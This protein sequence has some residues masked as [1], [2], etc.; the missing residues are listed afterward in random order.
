LGTCPDQACV[1][2]DGSTIAPRR[3]TSLVDKIA[4]KFPSA[5]CLQGLL[6]FYALYLL[7]AMFGRWMAVVPGAPVTVWPPNGVILAALLMHRKETWPWW[8][9]VGVIGEVTGNIFWYNSTFFAAV[10]YIFANS[11]AV[12]VAGLLMYPRFKEPIRRLTKLSEVLSLVAYGVLLTPIISATIGSALVA[13]EGKSAF[14]ATWP[15][16]WL[17]DATGVLIA[18]PFTIAAVNAWRDRSWPNLKQFCEGLA[19]AV[20]L[21]GITIWDLATGSIYTF[22]LPLPVL[23]AAMR[24]ELRGAALAVVGLTFAV[25]AHGHSLGFSGSSTETM[26]FV[27]SRMQVLILTAA[28]IGLLVAAI[29]R[30]LRHAVDTLAHSNIALEGRV[31]ERTKDIEASRQRF[32]AT[33]KNA[34]VGMS[35]VAGD[36][37]VLRANDNLAQMLGYD[38]SEMEEIALDDLTHPEDLAQASAA[39]EQVK[40]GASDEYDLEKRYITK[41]GRVVWGHTTV[42]AVREHAG[43]VAYLIKIIQDI[44]SRKESEQARDMLMREVNHRS[45]NLLSVVKVIARQTANRPAGDFMETFS[46][47]LQAL[48]ANQDILVNN[49]WQQIE[50]HNLVENQIGHFKSIISRVEIAGPEVKVS[51]QAA[52]AIGMAIHELATN[53]AKYGS[54]SNDAGK[55]AINW[56]VDGA[57]FKMSWRESEGPAVA[58]PTSQGFGTT[59][60]DKLMSSSLSAEIKIDFAADGLVWTV[61]CPLSKLQGNA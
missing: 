31:L 13:F 52:Q 5:P 11:A 9:A 38:L 30:Q 34:G 47:R 35:I 7:A 6:G 59:V 8:I 19:I 3:T 16:W 54:L 48:A 2:L 61:A 51:P 42:S 32:E 45:K 56:T 17:G 29:V 40:S 23:W 58:R 36:G 14:A 33:F 53:A 21:I 24:F 43:E 15:L 57:N 27:H 41:D 12:L 26:A 4:S 10:G 55:V 46:N 39:L 22:L 60:I 49:G 44:T 25:G 50:M 37:R 20:L 28:T 18:T 1:D